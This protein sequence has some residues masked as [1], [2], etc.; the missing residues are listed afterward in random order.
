M[1]PKAKETKAKINKWDYTKVK[2]CTA[3]EII[4]K[5]KRQS[6]TSLVVQW[7]TLHAPNAGGPGS[8]PGRGTRSHVHAATKSLHAATKDPA[9]Q[10]E[11][12]TCCN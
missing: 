4:N 7:V 11:D 6:G 10:K 8:I 5:M 2:S 1:T 3:K 9:C 12:P